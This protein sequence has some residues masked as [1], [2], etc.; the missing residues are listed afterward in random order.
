[1]HFKF[2]LQSFWLMIPFKYLNFVLF[3]PTMPTLWV[4]FQLFGDDPQ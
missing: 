2:S 4:C 1:M 3:N